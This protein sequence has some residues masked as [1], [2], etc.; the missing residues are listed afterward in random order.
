M[1]PL[2]IRQKLGPVRISTPVERRQKGHALHTAVGPS[3]IPGAGEGLFLLEP[4]E[5]GN[6][7]ARYAGEVISHEE[8]EKRRAQG[9][10]YIVQVNKSVCID[11]SKEKEWKG[12]KVNYGGPRQEENNARISRARTYNVCPDTGKC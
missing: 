6:R 1:A 8:A 2:S 10:V 5:K 7:V 11:G 4:A 9:N 3:T 12:K